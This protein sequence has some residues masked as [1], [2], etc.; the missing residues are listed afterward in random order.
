M[1]ITRFQKFYSLQ[2]VPL[3]HLA[4]F[5]RP[6]GRHLWLQRLCF[7]V[8][9]YLGAYVQEKGV[10]RAELDPDRLLE[11]IEE[12]GYQLSHLLKQRMQTIVLGPN[13]AQR[14]IRDLPPWEYT[15]VV[16][17]LDFG[18][19]VRNGVEYRGR[20]YGM[21]VVVVPWFDGVLL[22]PKLED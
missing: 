22:L 18:R 1:A 6:L 20:L 14:V 11:V 8:L 9:R 15:S 19:K 17:D 12:Q 10:T 7:K 4:Y 5:E 2:D 16:L 13:E 21:R 3:D